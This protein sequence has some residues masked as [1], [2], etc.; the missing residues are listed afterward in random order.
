M[1]HPWVVPP[2]YRTAPERFNIATEVVDRRVAQGAGDIALRDARG[3][4][5]FG[6][7]ADLVARCAGGLDS[8]GVQRGTPFLIRSPNCREAY[9]T[10]LAG[11][12]LGAVPILANS[13][14]GARELG[15]VVDNGA[16]ALAALPAAAP[17]PGAARRRSGHAF[18]GVAST[19]APRAAPVPL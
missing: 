19:V 7:L 6:A 13:L 4:V 12:K 16:P 2:G 17:A 8:L 18:R 9:V 3:T 1:R 15:H 11:V 5:T 14:L 10:F